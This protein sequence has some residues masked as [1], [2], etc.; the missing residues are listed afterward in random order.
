MRRN[1]LYS[2]AGVI[3]T[4]FAAS[5]RAKGYCGMTQPTAKADTA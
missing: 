2:I 4:L 1:E 5:A 3:F